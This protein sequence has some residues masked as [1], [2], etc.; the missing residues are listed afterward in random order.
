MGV[1]TETKQVYSCE[2]HNAEQIGYFFCH[3]KR[4][5]ETAIAEQKKMTVHFGIDYYLI[6]TLG[7]LCRMRT[8]FFARRN[9]IFRKGSVFCAVT[10]TKTS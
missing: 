8:E 9:F 2:V 7:D 4:Y 6:S 3:C 5:L 1:V 10:F